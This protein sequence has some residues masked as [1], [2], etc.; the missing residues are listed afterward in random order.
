[1]WIQSQRNTVDIIGG[2]RN[3]EK[4]HSIH[5]YNSTL[6]LIC[7]Y[8][9]WKKFF[10]FVILHNFFKKII[11]FLLNLYIDIP[12]RVWYNIITKIEQMFGIKAKPS[13]AAKP[14]RKEK[15]NVRL[16]NY[17]VYCRIFAIFILLRI[18]N[19]FRHRKRSDWIY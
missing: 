17:K 7:K 9:F 16:Q 10:Y 13:P 18:H 19:E 12:S 15:R 8:V 3:R 6:S 2:W 14:G 1:M 5:H 4:C 11:Y